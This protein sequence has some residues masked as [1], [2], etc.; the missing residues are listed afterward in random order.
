[1][2][3]ND[4]SEQAAQNQPENEPAEALSPQETALR[5]YMDVHF[6]MGALRH[7]KMHNAGPGRDPM[8]GQGRILALLRLTDGVATKDMAQIIG[9]RVSSL[10][11]SLAKLEREGLVKRTPSEEDKRIMLVSLTDKGRKLTP[12]EDKLPNL[13]F[14]GFSPDELAAFEGYLDRIVAN[15]EK[16]LG[17]DAQEF[18]ENMRQARKEFFEQHKGRKHHGSGCGSHHGGPH[19]AP[20]GHGPHDEHGPHGGHHG[21]P[22]H[23][24]PGHGHGPGRGH[25]PHGGPYM[26]VYMKAYRW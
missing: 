1:M 19:D 23:G 18:L 2:T 5:K 22:G 24:G 4:Y 9:V 21:G 13:L 26:K 7:R 25:G 6:I 10:N 12:K 16:E 8:R 3:E 11:E 20:E 17:E 14:D 15:L